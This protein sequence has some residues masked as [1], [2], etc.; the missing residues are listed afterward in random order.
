MPDLKLFFGFVLLLA[1]AVL[2]TVAAYKANKHARWEHLCREM[3]SALKRQDLE[4]VEE[5]AAE[6][7]ASGWADLKPENREMLDAAVADMRE[8]DEIRRGAV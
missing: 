8:L 3:A 2:T 5:V 1:F 7:E 6:L 4:R